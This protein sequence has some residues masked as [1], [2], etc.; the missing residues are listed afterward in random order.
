MGK[1][2]GICGLGFRSLSVDNTQ[3][4]F[5]NIMDQ[6]L[7]DK[8]VFSFYLPSSSGNN[9]ELL[10]GGIDKKHYTGD[11]EYLS[12]SSETYWELKLDSLKFGTETYTDTTKVI[13]DSGTSLL[14][15]PSDVVAKI[16]KQVGAYK[17]LGKE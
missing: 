2:D 16:A 8:N 4:L 14:A 3:T 11:L 7:V 12:L 13:I 6:K 1:F 17:I 5:G 15:G 10:L 9:G